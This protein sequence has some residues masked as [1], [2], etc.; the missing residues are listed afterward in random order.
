MCQDFDGNDLVPLSLD[1]CVAIQC[2]CEYA[3]WRKPPAV[4]P[5]LK[6]VVPPLL[7]SRLKPVVPPLFAVSRL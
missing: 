7:A 1:L 2:V 3:H 4:E 6:P 5:R